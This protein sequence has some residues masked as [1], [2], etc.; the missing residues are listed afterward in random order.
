MIDLVLR[1]DASSKLSKENRTRYFPSVSL[2]WVMSREDFWNVPFIDF[3]KLRGSWGQNGSIQ[4][5]GTFEY[6]SL[7][8]TGAESSYYV[9]GGTRVA[10]SEPS[11]LSNPDLVWETSQQIDIGLLIVLYIITAQMAPHT[12]V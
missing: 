12:D 8:T 2:G 4:S 9:S 10:G 11:A 1:A 6:V 5:L 7:I 3:F